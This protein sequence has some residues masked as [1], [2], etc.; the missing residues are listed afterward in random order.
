MSKSRKRIAEIISITQLFNYDSV[1]CSSGG[2]VGGNVYTNGIERVSVLLKPFVQNTCCHA[3]QKHFRQHLNEVTMCLNPSNRKVDSID[4]IE[5]FI[6][7]IVGRWI[8][9]WGPV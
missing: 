4:R 7:G 9:C 5:A 3:F 2:Y 8:A 6:R 1:F